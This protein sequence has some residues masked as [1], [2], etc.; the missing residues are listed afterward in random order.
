MRNLDIKITEWRRQMSAGGIK[1]PSVL[2][3]LEAH[4]REDVESQMRAGWEEEKAFD[5]AVQR[6]G[7]SELLKAEFAKIQ[8]RT[9]SRAAKI[10]GIGC[11]VFA[12]LYSL[13]LAPH[14]FT[15]SELT[16]AQRL[17]GFAAV[18]VT[19][20]S[21]ASWRFSYRFLPAIRNPRARKAA[22]IV[23]GIAG[24]AWILI[25][26]IL[27]PN[28]I[29]PFFMSGGASADS[30]RGSVLIGLQHASPEG[31]RAV[32]M[33]GLSLLWAMTL[34]AVLGAVAYGLDGAAKHHAKKTAY[35]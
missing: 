24:F 27:L 13:L 30:V 31:F 9:E 28:V 14:L 3:E 34:A 22:G 19:F 26:A 7:K 6:I 5:V 35:V 23:C 25:F 29:V 21:L 12:G 15:I 32:F 10:I 18:A 1:S 4:L 20:F 16:L 8:R 2:D 33:I 11:C 17:L